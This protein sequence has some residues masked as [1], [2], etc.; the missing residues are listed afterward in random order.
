MY[1]N[2][3]TVMSEYLSDMPKIWYYDFSGDNHTLSELKKYLSDDRFSY[4]SG[5]KN[6]VSGLSS[7]Y[8]YLLLRYALKTEYG[9]S[10]MPI[11]TTGEHGKPFLE[12]HRD[13]FF[14]I[15]HAKKRVICS[16]SDRSVGVDIQDIR[17]ISLNT[18]EK[19][20]SETEMKAVSE[21]TDVSE[22][23]KELSRIWCIKESY[24]KMTGKGFAEGFCSINTAE[25]L[26]QKKV[27]VTIKDNY[28][29]SICS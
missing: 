24:S 10:D 6:I 1:L 29:I 9:I 18:A 17:N 14:N 3:N 4:C 5:M 12:D 7:A 25:L 27:F 15:S 8:G 22:R 16:V 28:Y 19:F 23:D 2:V 20:L 13:I 26:E 11:I 21:I